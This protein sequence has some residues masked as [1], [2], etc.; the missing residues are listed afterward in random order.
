VAEERWLVGLDAQARLQG[1]WYLQYY[2]PLDRLAFRRLLRAHGALERFY[3][4]RPSGPWQPDE[5]ETRAVE[6]RRL[7][8]RI[9]E[10][11]PRVGWRRR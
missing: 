9:A 7:R 3:R 5:A 2:V 8:A 11:T 1:I 10:L 6:S 4:A